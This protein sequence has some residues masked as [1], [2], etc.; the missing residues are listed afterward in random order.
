MPPMRWASKGLDSGMNPTIPCRRLSIRRERAHR[1]MGKRVDVP[2]PPCQ[3]PTM[4][5]ETLNQFSLTRAAFSA[6]RR[7][8]SKSL[9][10]G[11]QNDPAQSIFGYSIY[12]P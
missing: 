2:R 9:S 6:G 7:V 4:V 10:V 5:N 12:N 3:R 1:S 11:I 8:K